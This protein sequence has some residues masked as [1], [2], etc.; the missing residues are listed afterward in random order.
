MFVPR[1]W[2][3]QA[4]D[5]LWPLLLD[6]NGPKTLLCSVVMGAGKTKFATWLAYLALKGKLFDGV[7][8]LTPPRGSVQ[9]QWKLA[10]EEL[11]ALL[12]IEGLE[13]A[14]GK[15]VTASF[16][17]VEKMAPVGSTILVIADEIHHLVIGKTWGDNVNAFAAKAGR[18]VL[19]SATPFREDGAEIP[20][21]REVQ[22]ELIFEYSYGAA[23]K[24][25]I[26]RYIQAHDEY[27]GVMTWTEKGRPCSHTFGKIEDDEFVP[28]PLTKQQDA[29]RFST[30][31]KASFT[32]TQCMIKDAVGLLAHMRKTHPRAQGMIVVASKLD[33]E[34]VAE[35]LR[36]ECG[37][38]PTVVHSD[39]G[40]AERDLKKFIRNTG[41]ICA[42]MISI[43]L[44]SEGTDVP[45]LCVL[46]YNSRI[47]TE[48]FMLQVAGRV[49]RESDETKG[50]KAQVFYPK[51]EQVRNVFR[52]LQQE[53]DAALAGDSFEPQRVVASEKAEDASD[54]PDED[55]V[56]MEWDQCFVNKVEDG[57]SDGSIDEEA[58][59]WH[60]V[61]ADLVDPDDES[62]EL[63]A[64]LAMFLRN[65][66]KED[67]AV[68]R[69]EVRKIWGGLKALTAVQIELS[70]AHR[71]GRLL[72]K[73][74]HD[75]AAYVK[76][77]GRQLGVR[78]KKIG[79]ILA[80]EKARLVLRLL[81][82][83]KLWTDERRKP[84]DLNA[85]ELGDIIKVSMPSRITKIRRAN[86]EA[87]RDENVHS[88]GLAATTPCV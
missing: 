57:S 67:P 51:D 58:E 22:N 32:L 41:D 61:A 72:E 16:L 81:K 15:V 14:A 70:E 44:V 66:S 83:R 50:A 88:T 52:G 35:F 75:V 4:K 69:D 56:A 63:K 28:T 9:D 27:D 53:A 29:R 40:N 42:W 74:N 6:A 43:T 13:D 45:N 23:V 82:R 86:P 48:L 49:M 8:F 55:D 17:D 31:I 64:V 1:K 12:R 26:C 71:R 65:R 33:A 2:Q 68:V 24:D 46:V 3:Q 34:E 19:L 59:S 7:V 78:G 60:S 5:V 79:G 25:G 76:A 85:E 30:A 77:N 39:T 20:F 84:T 47:R 37:I 87:G 54:T 21:M 10:A 62:D 80:R 38:D 36:K 18:R 11:R 73:F